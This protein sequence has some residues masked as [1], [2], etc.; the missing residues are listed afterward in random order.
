MVCPSC[1]IIPVV[2]AGFALSLTDQIYLGYL[3]TVLSLCIY[4]HYKEI[5]K[6]NQCI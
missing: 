4:L 1:L 3:L 2:A 5:K 6:C